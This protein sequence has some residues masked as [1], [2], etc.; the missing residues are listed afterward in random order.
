[1]TRLEQPCGIFDEDGAMTEIFDTAYHSLS[2]AETRRLYRLLS[3]HRGPD[4][5][6]DAAAALAG[7]TSKATAR[8]LQALADA[9]LLHEEQGGR[10]S[11]DDLLREHARATADSAGRSSCPEDG[12]RASVGVG[13]RAER[14]LNVAD[15]SAAS[16]AVLG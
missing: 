3:L 4:I 16:M 11:F 6:A 5:T 9:R 7:T 15:G 12:M 2:D 1:L 10:Y 13:R 14:I 8:R